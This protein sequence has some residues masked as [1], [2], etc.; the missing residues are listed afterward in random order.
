MELKKS[1]VVEKADAVTECAKEEPNAHINRYFA[2]HDDNKVQRTINILRR[3]NMYCQAIQFLLYNVEL[4][5]M[6]NTFKG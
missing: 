6:N 2:I 3:L 1:A 5:V 4:A